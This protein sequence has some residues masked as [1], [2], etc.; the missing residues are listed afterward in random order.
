[1]NEKLPNNR[2]EKDIHALL[3]YLNYLL[4]IIIASWGVGG[5]PA[6]GAPPISSQEQE[7]A[8]ALI[9]QSAQATEQAWEEFHAAAIG[10]TLASPAVQANI[11]RQLH[12]ARAL[13]MEARKAERA[14]QHDSVKSL[15]EK[16]IRITQNI[17]KASREKKQ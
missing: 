12:E 1:M 8:R 16:I 11:E 5:A 9:Y 6:L 15:T 14:K 4:F 3:S 2:L 10:G 7:E 13:L 17:V